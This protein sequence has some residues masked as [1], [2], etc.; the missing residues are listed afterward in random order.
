MKTKLIST[1]KK[2]L[3]I[4][5]LPKWYKSF[6]YQKPLLEVRGDEPNLAEFLSLGR[7]ELLGSPDEIKEDE[8]KELVEET[9]M[10]V[11]LNSKKYKYRAYDSQLGYATATES[12]LSAIE[13]EIYWENPYGKEPIE[14]LQ[15]S[16]FGGE[17]TIIHRNPMN[18]LW[19]EAETRNFE[20]NR[21][22]IFVKN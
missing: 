16:T 19:H 17:K 4:I 22:L 2:D 20:R 7:Y 13:S 9:E 12:L 6:N 5:E 3:L 11:K 10:G 1:L 21:T 14:N 8:A 18:I 15:S